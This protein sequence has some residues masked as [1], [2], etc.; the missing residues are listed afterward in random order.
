M[1]RD[2]EASRI[3]Y[4]GRMDWDDMRRAAEALK[5]LTGDMFFVPLA[6]GTV[7][8]VEGSFCRNPQAGLEGNWINGAKLNRRGRVVAWNFREHQLDAYGSYKYTDRQVPARNVWQH[9][10]YDCRLNQIRGY[11][12]IASI[13]NEM[14]D[15][16]ETFDHARAKVKLD[17]MFGVAIFRKADDA[18][19]LG[20]GVDADGNATEEPAEQ[21]DFGGGPFVMDRET[22]EDVKL[23]T[24]SNPA[25]DTQEF[26]KLCIQVAL[27]S[28]D[29]PYNF[30][31]EAHTNF[32]GSR[33]AWILYERSCWARRQT[34]LRLHRRMTQWRLFNWTLPVDMGGT[35]EISIPR[36]M[37]MDDLAY[38]WVSRGLPWW[39]PQEELSTQIMAA[40]VGLKDWQQI[41]DENNLGIYEENIAALS[42][43]RDEIE[44]FG[45]VMQFNPSKLMAALQP[46]N[47]APVK[48][49]GA[50]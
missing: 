7:Q 37:T 34:Q 24:A 31:D 3:D 11:S 17:Q 48:N 23:L 36:S 50:V 19:D 1:A 5:I 9:V 14:R 4:V 20:T 45:Y 27:K 30:F 44:K 46:V 38:R 2:S 25:K 10:Q 13:L 6:E 42:R 21:Y 33:S 49:G 26:L 22:G 18:D 12:P 16:G 8:A 15:I 47:A 41:C 39:K 28:L 43:Q 32:F 35:G 40:A 29:L